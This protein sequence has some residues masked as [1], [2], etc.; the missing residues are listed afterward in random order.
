MSFS[1]RVC[2]R[3]GVPATG[4]A[5]CGSCGLDLQAEFQLP[6]RDVWEAIR[7]ERGEAHDAF[8]TVAQESAPSTLVAPASDSPSAYEPPSASASSPPSPAACAAA[9]SS[10]GL[11]LLVTGAVVAFVS[12]LLPWVD[13]G[14]FSFWELTSAADVLLVVQLV[15]LV[16][17]CAWRI[18]RQRS[19]AAAA[20]VLLIA[21]TGISYGAP[22][23]V[24]FIVQIARFDAGIGVGTMVAVLAAVLLAVGVVLEALA[25]TRG[26]AWSRPSAS[27]A[28]F[29]LAALALGG[30]L[31]PLALLLTFSDGT[32]GWE[33][34]RVS[35]IAYT[36]LG[37]A[38]AAFALAALGGRRSTITLL[39]AAVLGALLG[40]SAFTGAVD[41]LADSDTS[42]GNLVILLVV[43]PLLVAGTVALAAGWPRIGTDRE[44]PAP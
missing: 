38:L 14:S 26:A 22:D 9:P 30:A 11:A 4:A 41:G 1:E 3:C 43:A 37:L 19:V 6:T 35:D 2:P 16:A 21:A 15:A 40:W 29:G 10:L 33:S 20:S 8:G 13:T 25:V 18:V 27:R 39:V 32:T 31:I 34:A 23:A 7:A 17:A 24:E 12:S 42:A 36:A 28:T 5:V 44:D